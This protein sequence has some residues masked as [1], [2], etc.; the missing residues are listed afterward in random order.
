MAE[1]VVFV[2]LPASGKS[3]FYRLRFA[4]THELVSKDLLANN[5]QPSRRQRQLISAALLRGHSVVVD[6]TN[7]RRTDRAELLALAKAGGATTAVY[8]FTAALA[9]CLRRN[10][11]RE[12]KARVPDVA[13]FVAA[14]RLDAPA[15]DEGFDARYEVTL[16]ETSAAFSVTRR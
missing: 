7:T 5:R 10:K 2:G 3:T 6:N 13:L 11:L 1:L 4:A 14:K 15:D 9:D 16:D 8:H 12:G